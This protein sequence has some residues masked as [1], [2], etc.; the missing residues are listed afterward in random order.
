MQNVKLKSKRKTLTNNG[1]E[2]LGYNQILS[3]S[4]TSLNIQ[5]DLGLNSVRYNTFTIK[6]RL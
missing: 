3:E 5:Y 4:V 6:R 1:R 2:I